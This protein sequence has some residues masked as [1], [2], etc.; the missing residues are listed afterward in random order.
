M[1]GNNG[2]WTVLYEPYAPD[3]IY[4]LGGY[5]VNEVIDWID[6]LPTRGLEERR[7]DGVAG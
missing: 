3:A 7:L 5:N 6:S 2:G 1:Q 4:P